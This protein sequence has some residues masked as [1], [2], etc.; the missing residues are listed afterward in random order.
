MTGKALA[1]AVSTAVALLAAGSAQPRAH[2][3]AK[4]LSLLGIVTNTSG[5][6]S[7]VRVDPVRLR[8]RPGARMNVTH[9]SGWAFSPGKR[10]LA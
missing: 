3:P 8:A 2:A 7:L 1:A 9:V 10:L 5:Q 6:Q 4:V